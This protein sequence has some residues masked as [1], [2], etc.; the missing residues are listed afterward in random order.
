MAAIATL[1]T[2]EQPVMDARVLSLSRKVEA[3]S[4]EYEVLEDTLGRM[5]KDLE[6]ARRDLDAAR[7]QRDT[8]RKEA[9]KAMREINTRAARAATSEPKAVASRQPL[10]VIKKHAAEMLDVSVDFFDVHIAPEVRCVR[11]GR[12]R[13]YP[14][15]ELQAWLERESER[16]EYPHLRSVVE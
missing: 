7:L 9:S 4:G 15:S 16:A 5:S 2:G 6:R 14:V 10:A 12:R 13:L 8:Y 1:L 11:R 3:L